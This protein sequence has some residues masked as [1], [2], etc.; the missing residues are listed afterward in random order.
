MLKSKK[1]QML[2]YGLFIGLVAAILVSLV[3]DTQTK[4][5]FPVIGDTALSLIEN[6]KEAEKTL[7][8]IDQSAKYA[9]HQLVYDLASE[10]GCEGSDR[11]LQYSVWNDK[12]NLEDVKTTF[13]SL[14]SDKLDLFLS[15]YDSIKIPQTNYDFEIRGAN[16][17]GIAKTPLKIE[18][19][20]NE[21]K[22]G[23]YSI[24][25]SFKIGLDYD[26]SEYRELKELSEKFVDACK[27]F[28][29]KDG[30][31]KL[32]K[33]QFFD[34][35]IGHKF[36]L[37]ENCHKEGE[38]HLEISK[39]IDS[40]QNSKISDG[41]ASGC[42]CRNKPKSEK[43]DIVKNEDKILVVEK[44]FIDDV[45][46]FLGFDEKL[47]HKDSSGE[48]H[49]LEDVPS[50]EECVV[51]K[52]KHVFCVKSNSKFLVY[53]DD[54]LETKNLVYKFALDFKSEEDSSATA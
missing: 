32:N 7:L 9:S 34:D 24:R 28:Q 3:D 35:P 50:N 53:E 27:N 16:L 39:Y 54:V 36:E 38:E 10:G 20:N 18:R 30:C 40:C 44:D 2:M 31:V 25:P 1:G 33:K 42:V 49:V 26:F 15:N 19:K 14:F 11:Y 52:T 47:L 41:Q 13:T 17:L 46:S 6:S 4:N 22:I 51:E 29:N 5:K 23:M 37:V 12:C 45:E 48:L 21:K 8:F 43:Y